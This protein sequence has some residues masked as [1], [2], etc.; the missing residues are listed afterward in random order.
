MILTE[1][2]DLLMQK[3][4]INQRQLSQ[5]T[6]IPYSTI[7]NW[8]K[9]ASNAQ[10]AKLGALKSLR[11]YFSVT[12]D[13]LA[14]DNIDDPNFGKENTLSPP[15]YSDLCSAYRDTVDVMSETLF[16]QQKKEKAVKDESSAA[17]A[18]DT[19]IPRGDELDVEEELKAIR[20]ELELEKRERTL[21]ASANT[22]KHAGKNGTEQ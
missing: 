19:P 3:K 18:A 12:L 17:L 8:Y 20:R 14:D 7:S 4:G 2:L 1:K 6:G 15:H 5:Q 22:G 16:K 21:K 9:D 10:N 13:Y 11:Q